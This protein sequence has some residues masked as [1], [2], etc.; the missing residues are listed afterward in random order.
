MK[1]AVL[2][3]TESDPRRGQRFDP[4]AFYDEHRDELVAFFERAAQRLGIAYSAEDVYHDAC[5]KLLARHQ[6]VD[7]LNPRRAVAW[8]K[9]VGTNLLIDK[10]RE[11][12][13]KFE[14]PQP[15]LVIIGAESERDAVNPDEQWAD[16]EDLRRVVVKMPDKLAEVF[17][18]DADGY[19]REEIAEMLDLKPGTVAMRLSRARAYAR[20]RLGIVAA[21]VPLGAVAHAARSLRRAVTKPAQVLVTSIAYVSIVVA[22]GIPIVPGTVALPASATHG[23]VVRT[24]LAPVG[25]APASTGKNAMS[26]SGASDRRAPGVAHHPA[27]KPAGPGLVPRVPR[28]CTSG[29]CVGSSCSASDE[30]GDVLYLKADGP[31]GL[32]TTENTTPVCQYVPDNPA[33]GCQRRGKP[34]W[35]VDPPSPPSPEG[36]PL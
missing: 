22:F 14:Q 31:C 23:A 11:G 16:R 35:K 15:N 5:L 4:G 25:T 6:K 12:Y 7:T 21:F 27:S 9:K 10:V 1:G 2:P 19:S 24:A 17:V 20:N 36:E 33:V 13:G 34:Q 29:V 30:S 18:H 28:T 26:R 32:S 8:V 3:G